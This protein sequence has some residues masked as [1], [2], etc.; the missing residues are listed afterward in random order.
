[1]SYYPSSND[2]L[3]ETFPHLGLISVRLWVKMR[4]NFLFIRS[5]FVLLGC[6]EG[7]L[8]GVGEGV[9]KQGVSK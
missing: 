4:A 5:P 7:V 6:R 9:G 1:M 2:I 8:L 3:H